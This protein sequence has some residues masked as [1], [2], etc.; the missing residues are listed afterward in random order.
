MILWL[1]KT[2]SAHRLCMYCINYT[3]THPAQKQ[4]VKKYLLDPK[5][6]EQDFDENWFSLPTSSAAIVDI[7]LA[8]VGL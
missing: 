3:L 1:G 6:Q 5:V 8:C 4:V 2:N 7:G